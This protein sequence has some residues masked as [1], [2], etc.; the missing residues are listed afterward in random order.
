ME[1]HG[2]CKCVD[3]VLF[4]LAEGLLLR[5]R[6]RQTGKG[7]LLSQ[8]GPSTQPCLPIRNMNPSGCWEAFV[9]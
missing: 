9:H 8:E 1:P 4:E 3:D 2:Q 6:S 5:T 7:P